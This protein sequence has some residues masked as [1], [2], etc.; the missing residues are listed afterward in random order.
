MIDEYERN[1]P[2]KVWPKR[3]D[4]IK[5]RAP[6]SLTG[7]MVFG[8]GLS[9]CGDVYDGVHVDAGD[10]CGWVIPFEALELAYLEN[11]RVRDEAGRE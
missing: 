4:D 3:G 2:Y 11:K 5:A 9:Q 1:M 6:G 10:G 7:I 8:V